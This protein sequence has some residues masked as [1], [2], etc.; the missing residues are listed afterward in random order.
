MLYNYFHLTKLF[1]SLLDLLAQPQS[2]QLQ[3]SD[4]APATPA[5]TD[6]TGNYHIHVYTHAYSPSHTL[7]HIL[8]DIRIAVEL[9]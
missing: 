3:S 1:L 8:S 9:S 5:T 7:P 2:S 4:P 6:D